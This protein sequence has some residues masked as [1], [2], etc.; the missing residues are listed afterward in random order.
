MV[1]GFLKK[2]FST[3]AD[4]YLSALIFALGVF[5]CCDKALSYTTEV[6]FFHVC[7][8][9]VLL[10]LSVFLFLTKK[11]R[12]S[13]LL[14][15]FL[16][17]YIALNLL[18]K[19]YGAGFNLSAEYQVISLFVAINWL[20]YCLL[21]FF[22]LSQVFDFYF[23]CL[24]LLEGTF[25]E[26][27]SVLSI[28]NLNSS[29]EFFIIVF[30]ALLF[31]LYMVYVSIFPSKENYGEFFAFLSL[32][33]GVFN[34]ESAFSLSLYFCLSALILF[35][36]IV[37]NSVYCYF[38][39]NLTGIY[40]N[41]SFMHHAVKFPLKYSLGIICIDDYAKLVKVFPPLQF[42]KLIKMAVNK[43]EE[44]SSGA[45]IYRYHD[46]EFILIFKNEDKKQCFEYLENIRRAIAG[47][48]FVLN[49]KRVVKIT[50]SA[51]VSEKKRSD[52]DF[53]AVLTRTR[54]AVQRTYKFTQNMTT[55]A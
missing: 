33:L 44:L 36:S 27:M 43:I 53:D 3:T 45:D 6:D 39:D 55:M 38:K 35:I 29:F 19:H 17:T 20:I 54:D 42:E 7:F 11:S 31:V 46:D 34:S 28:N 40:S 1:L 14:L 30:W 18:K 9:V 4:V 21:K 41:N 13:V 23:L 16:G 5:Y 50:I 47:A 49:S 48:E 12:Q 25:I 2:I 22:K 51:G 15:T 8:Y 32:G 26:N 24:F 52:A 10:V 37:S